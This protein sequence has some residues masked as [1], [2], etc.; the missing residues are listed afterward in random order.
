MVR[1]ALLLQILFLR[2]AAGVVQI[3]PRLSRHLLSGT[4]YLGVLVVE[5]QH[6][7]LEGLETH[8]VHLRLRVTMVE[9][10]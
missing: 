1:Q 2:V 8:Q 9:L 4:V 3:M 6:L 5:V 10:L 7:L